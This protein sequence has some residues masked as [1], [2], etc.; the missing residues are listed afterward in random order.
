M[1]VAQRLLGIP[2]SGPAS[3]CIHCLDT[4]SPVPKLTQLMRGMCFSYEAHSIRSRATDIFQMYLE[5]RCM[6]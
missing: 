5:T 3:V 1:D 4:L 2:A 6:Q